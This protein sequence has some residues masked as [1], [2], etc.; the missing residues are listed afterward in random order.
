MRS[1]FNFLHRAGRPKLGLATC[2]AT[3][4]TAHGCGSDLGECDPDAARELVFSRQ[5]LV[6]T[7]GQALL[8]DSCG[9]GAFC[10]SAAAKGGQRHGVPADLDFDM[11]PEPRGWPRVMELRE[12][13]WEVV[14]SGEMPPS[15]AGRKVLGDG[16]WMFDWR[17]SEGSAMLPALAA[18]EGQAALRNWLACDA[19]LV[20][21]TKVPLW[22]RTSASVPS[23]VERDFA[24]LH[25]TILMP[26]CA[27]AGCHDRA[28][29]GALDM[30]DACG[31]FRA[32]QVAGPCGAPRVRAGDP[33]SLLL[34]K[35]AADPPTCGGPMPP[36][37]RL[38]DADVEALR[39]WVTD[40]A[41]P[42]PD[43]Q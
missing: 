20:S 28:A 34:D 41:L 43:C 27:T 39:A 31:A 12:S 7:K 29:A 8:H 11:L 9:N 37:G 15:E 30:S 40:G 24:A 18:H 42:P 10:H 2:L 13:I 35:L 16:A 33:A 3:L 26:N 19:P 21:E 22:A 14:V 36:T 23:E 1:T 5:G 4:L 25:A 32:L 17:R 38:P 6:A